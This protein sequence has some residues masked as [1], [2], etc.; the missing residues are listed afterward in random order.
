MKICLINSLYEPYNR[1][2]AEDIVRILAQYLAKHGHQIYII[3]SDIRSGFKT[4]VYKENIGQ[5]RLFRVQTVNIASFYNLHRIWPILRVG[6]HFI[7]TINPF[8]YLALKRIIK[9]IKPDLIWAHNLKGL[10]YINT[11]L[12]RKNQAVFWQTLHDVQYYD[13]SGLIIYDKQLNIFYKFARWIYQLI[14][15]LSLAQPDLVISPSQWLLDFYEAK[16]FFKKAKKINLLNPINVKQNHVHDNKGKW[17]RL[18]FVGQL[19][20]HKGVNFLIKAFEQY[21]KDHHNISLTIVGSGSL[22]SKVKADIAGIDIKFIDWVESSKLP[23]LISSHD[24]VVVPSLCY[25]NSPTIINMAHGLGKPVLA[26][27]IGGIAE[28]IEEDVNGWLFAPNNIDAFMQKLDYIQKNNLIDK[29]DQIKA[30]ALP[31]EDYLG[32]LLAKL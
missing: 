9:T 27:A 28:M 11:R 30:K 16:G 5:I 14:V 4:R 29:V 21:I 10:S 23:T 32:L 3:S 2:G 19:E 22:K 26:S 25:E 6:W 20:Q 17:L 12:F 15:K 1:G 24:M 8:T 31:V 13:P 18:L 7:D